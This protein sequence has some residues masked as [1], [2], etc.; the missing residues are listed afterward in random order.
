MW[1]CNNIHYGS[2]PI[3]SGSEAS[4]KVVKYQET[5]KGNQM[6]SNCKLFVAPNSCQTVDGAII[7]VR[8]VVATLWHR[9]TIGGSPFSGFLTR[10]EIGHL[11]IG[12]AG[13]DRIRS[14]GLLM[15]LASF[16]RW[17]GRSTAASSH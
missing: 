7:L 10:V 16:D 14:R 12:S 8:T 6:C 2:D 1:R 15:L 5:P 3:R 11:R 9:S 17:R 13:N 4:Q